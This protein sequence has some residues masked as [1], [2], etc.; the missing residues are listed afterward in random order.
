VIIGNLQYGRSMKKKLML[1]TTKSLYSNSCNKTTSI[2][3]TDARILILMLLSRKSKYMSLSITL[4]KGIVSRNYYVLKAYHDKW[5]HGYNFFFLA[6]EK[7]K[8]KVLACS[9]EIA[10]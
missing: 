9:F 8:L 2:K 7:V 10:D 1:S 6:D 3:L 5:V 4:F